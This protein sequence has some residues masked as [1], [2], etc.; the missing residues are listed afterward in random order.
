M[1]KY[2]DF[3]E[4]VNDAG[5]LTPF[6]NYIDPEIFTFACEGNNPKGQNYTGDPETDPT[7]WAKR[8]AEEKKLAYGCFFN[9][10]TGGYIAPR[11]YSLFTDAFRPR[12]TVEERY[13]SGKLGEYEWKVWTVLDKNN[14]SV[15]WSQIWQYHGIKDEAER[16]KLDAALKNLQMT[17]DIA[18]SGCVRGLNKN[19]TD[20]NFM[21]YQK[22]ADWVPQ[23]W[24]AMN[25]RMEH[26]EALEIIYRQAE[27]ISSSGD[28][29]KAFAK[30]LKLYKSFT[31]I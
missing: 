9:G 12:M 13:K 23:E 19:G 29:K 14:G 21:G 5:F 10:K 1:L 26:G 2:D 6:T 28:E 20:F 15:S 4:K 11:F 17:F 30:S 31:E 16:R 8:A 27:K 3:I 7:I 18:I 24:L 25:T 22:S